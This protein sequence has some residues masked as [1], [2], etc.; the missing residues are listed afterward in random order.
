MGNPSQNSLRLHNFHPDLS[1]VVLSANYDYYTESSLG[2]ENIL[3]PVLKVKLTNS[4][5][6]CLWWETYTYGMLMLENLL[7]GRF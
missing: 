7:A 2:G 4:S 6:S 5:P 1:T 3:F